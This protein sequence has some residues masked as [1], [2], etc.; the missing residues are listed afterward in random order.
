MSFF[1]GVYPA[2][3]HVSRLFDLARLISQPDYARKAH[4]TLR[5]PYEKRPSP[6]SK[7]L[8]FQ[9]SNATITRPS[10]FFNES[11]STVYLGV[12]FLEVNEVSWKPDFQGAIPHM[13]I[14]DGPDRSFAWQIFSLLNKFSWKL[15]IELTK[16][17]ILER[18]KDYDSAFFLELDDIDLAFK[19]I[20]ERPLKREYIRNMHPGQRLYL[21]EKICTALH[22]ASFT[23]PSSAP[24]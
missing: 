12:S 6:R 13:S 19:Y 2:D 3:K 16:V 20:L 9:P 10:K 22:E 8:Q 15:E 21:L 18:K 5:G 7:W 11:Q 17:L 23:H 14:Y 1:Y 4:I 24:K